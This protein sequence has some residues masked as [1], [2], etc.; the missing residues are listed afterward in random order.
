MQVCASCRGDE[1]SHQAKLPSS[2]LTC[3]WQAIQPSQ[4]RSHQRACAA[5]AAPAVN[6]HLLPT[7]HALTAVLRQPVH[8]AVCRHAA[9]DD[10]QVQKVDAL[11]RDARAALLVGP[12]QDALSVADV[13]A[14]AVPSTPSV[15]GDVNVDLSL[16]V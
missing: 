13:G 4:H 8:R 1:A 11:L 12:R 6:V 15:V 5:V 14:Q 9:V 2:L 10:R 7:Q 16:L 3:V